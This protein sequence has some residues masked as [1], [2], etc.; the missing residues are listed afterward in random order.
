MGNKANPRSSESKLECFHLASDDTFHAL[1]YL[2]SSDT[3]NQFCILGL[4]CTSI[5]PP[6]SLQAQWM[7]LH[8]RTAVYLV[9]R[10]TW[11]C[12]SW[13]RPQILV[14]W[15]P[16]HRYRGTEEGRLSHRSTQPS[17][18][19]GLLSVLVFFAWLSSPANLLEEGGYQLYTSTPY[20]W[21]NNPR[22]RI[23]IN[24][25]GRVTRLEACWLVNDIARIYIS[26]LGNS[27]SQ[28][29]LNYT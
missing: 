14:G 10:V 9:P 8:M 29:C 20:S 7:S 21:P 17:H 12:P 25:C 13:T 5:I 23:F 26:P 16:V 19:P 24:L 15:G 11:W 28:N 18:P 27:W 4:I 22:S 2:A 1:A 3:E 6:F